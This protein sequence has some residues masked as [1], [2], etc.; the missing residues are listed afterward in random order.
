MAGSPQEVTSPKVDVKALD[1]L[2]DLTLSADLDQ[3]GDITT[4]CAGLTGTV[5]A[6]I[7]ARAEGIFAGEAVLPRILEKGAPKVRLNRTSLIHDGKR[8]HP[9]EIVAKLVGPIEQILACERTLLNFM[10]RLCGVATLTNR[11]VE[12]VAA[13]HGLRR[14]G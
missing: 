13:M 5:T 11:F 12:A 6:R 7:E 10:Q 8:L 4:A 1:A 2:I 9:G 3:R 14:V